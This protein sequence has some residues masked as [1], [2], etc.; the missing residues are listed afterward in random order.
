[1][2]L[3]E[4]D[5]DT[6]VPPLRHRP[7]NSDPC[8]FP[9]FSQSRLREHVCTVVM[10]SGP[11]IEAEPLTRRRLIVG[12]TVAVAMTAVQSETRPNELS[13][14][15]KDSHADGEQR[16]LLQPVSTGG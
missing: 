7:L 3:R 5:T 14:H 9:L 16:R 8:L 6:H 12:P 13:V 1:M 11:I 4:S 2:L 15:I 10:T